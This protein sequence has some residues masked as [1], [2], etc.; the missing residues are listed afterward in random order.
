[1]CKPSDK[2]KRGKFCQDKLNDNHSQAHWENLISRLIEGD[3]EGNELYYTDQV[4]AI[5]SGLRDNLYLAVVDIS[6]CDSTYTQLAYFRDLFKKTQPDFKYF[7]YSNYILVL[8]STD[9]ITLN[10]KKYTCKLDRLFAEN[11]LYAGISSR[12]ENLFQLQK[13][14]REA[15]NLLN[16]GL[17]SDGSRRIFLHDDLRAELNGG[18]HDIKSVN[19]EFFYMS[20]LSKKKV[21]LR[22]I[23]SGKGIQYILNEAYSILGNPI[24]LHDMEY[25]VIAHT[26]NTVTD[27]PIW[28]EFES[29]GTVG[30]DTLVFFRDECFFEMAA[31]AEK[32]T[33]LLS[34]QLKYPRIFGKLFTKNNI[35]IGA[36]CMVFCYKPFEDDDLNLFD[37]LCDILNKEF[38]KSKFYENYGQTYM[39][40]LVGMLIEDRLEDKLLYTAHIE[41]IYKNLKTSLYI[42]VAD[43]TQCD[44]P[45]ITL[46]GFRD[47]LKRTQ[48]DFGYAVYANYIVIFLSFNTATLNVK[49]DLHKLN[50]FFKQHNIYVGISSCFENIIEL[51]KYYNEAINAL[52]NGLKSGGKQQIFLYK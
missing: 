18:P 50:K 42:A 23:K 21:Q 38:A 5:Y 6:Q 30:H 25:K 16:D 12:F 39:E 17:N 28:N 32:I 26:E 51:P 11:N 8:A 4:N 29:T 49:K 43:I 33:F 13:Y 2:R 36:A 46:A 40:T 22:K 37:I 27:D 7:I 15:V 41:S 9:N 10:V 14:Y 45:N 3:I 20:G 47:L 1:M 19:D 48:P 34:D 52:N 35:Q 44:S 31:N 24:L